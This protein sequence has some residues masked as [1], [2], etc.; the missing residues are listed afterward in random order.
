MSVGVAAQRAVC[1]VECTLAPELRHLI[2]ALA[3]LADHRTGEGLSGQERIA[4]AMGYSP[5]TVR[6][7]L[8]ELADASSPVVVMR[9]PRMRKHGRGRTSDAYTL[10]LQADTRDR[11]VADDQ[12]DVPVPLDTSDQEDTG[13]RLVT[14]DQPDTPER[15][16]GHAEHDQPDTGVRASYPIR[17]PIRDPVSIAPREAAA[18]TKPPRARKTKQQTHQADPRLLPLRDFYVER[19]QAANQ[20]AE[21]AFSRQTW[22]RA[23]R[24]FADL[25]EAAKTDERARLCIERTFADLWRRSNACQPWEIARDANKLLA[26]GGPAK[27]YVQRGGGD[28]DLDA[29]LQR[30]AERFGGAS[31][32]A[33]PEGWALAPPGEPEDELPATAA[34]GTA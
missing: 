16:T 12:A 30:G 2:L 9:T 14:H 31:E 23:M 13:D 26:L 32:S 28:R 24:A 21:P 27:A 20:G 34:G 5:R 22:G 17:D 11:V 7:L 15:P 1:A 25:L 18:H 6:R 10:A 33:K 19:Y 4:S 29:A 3:V 8:A